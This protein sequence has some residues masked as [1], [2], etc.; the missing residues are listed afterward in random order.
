[1]KEKEKTKTKTKQTNKQN[2]K[3]KKYSFTNSKNNTKIKSPLLALMSICFWMSPM[4]GERKY[5][6]EYNLTIA[7][8]NRFSDSKAVVSEIRQYSSCA[9]AAVP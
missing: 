1:M 2:S 7:A 9:S 3:K 6:L 5:W 8:Q 4:V